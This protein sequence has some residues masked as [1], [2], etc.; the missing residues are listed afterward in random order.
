[1]HLAKRLVLDGGLVGYVAEGTVYH[2]HHESWK[3]VERRFEREAIA[4]QQI[5][6][7]VLLRKRDIVG[8]IV[9][10][11][12]RDIIS[13]ASKDLSLSCIIK[14]I[15]YR[16]YQYIGSYKGNHSH[17]KMSSQLRDTYF[18]PT[19]IKRKKSTSH[20]K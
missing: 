3:Q 1:M 7:E 17:K 9:K 5:Y 6:P 12:T 20:S 14:I 8:Y 18:Y 11:I 15:N 19:P 4:L 2:I 16:F 10:G 13:K